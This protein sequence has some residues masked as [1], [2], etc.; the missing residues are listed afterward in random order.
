MKLIKEIND[1]NK[2]YEFD[3]NKHYR[4]TNCE[5]VKLFNIFL[6]QY[7]WKNFK[8]SSYN[9]GKHHIYVIFNYEEK[10]PRWVGFLHALEC[11]VMSKNII[12]KWH[13]VNEKYFKEEVVFIHT[14]DV[15][16][17]FKRQ[18][19]AT[20]MVDAVK[21]IFAKNAIIMVEAVKKGKKFWPS[22]GFKKVRRTLKGNFMVFPKDNN[23]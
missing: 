6:E 23:Y 14:I 22:V 11:D 5:E 16:E 4:N 19:Y 2:I 21:N 9:S 1:S 20:C 17:P 8:D 13:F 12:R 15:R 10:K 3:P 7:G 18:K